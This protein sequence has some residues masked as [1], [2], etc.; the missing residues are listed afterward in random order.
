MA[1]DIGAVASV[2]PPVPYPGGLILSWSGTLPAG[3]GFQVYVNGALSYRGVAARCHVPMPTGTAQFVIG[4]VPTSEIN[5][6]FSAS[7]PSL[8]ALRPRLSWGG[9]AF[10]GADIAGFRVYGEASPGVGL[11]FGA[12]LADLPAY[13]GAIDTSGFGVG[14]F[15]DPGF[16]AIGGSYSWEGDARTDGDWLF[17]VVPYDMAGNEGA[18]ATATISI[19]GPPPEPPPFPGTQERLRYAIVGWNQTTYGSGGFGLPAVALTWNA[20]IG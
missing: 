6:D 12:P 4:A 14:G 20:S 10:E 1:L 9:G 13:A 18:A 7:L 2:N 11:D 5:E 3:G 8:P 17:A 16:G 15:G 19:H